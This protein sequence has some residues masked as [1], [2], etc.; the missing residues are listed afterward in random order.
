MGKCISKQKKS[1]TKLDLH[2]YKPKTSSNT[3]LDCRL[4][5]KALKEFPILSHLNF[6]SGCL[7][8]KLDS[9]R[10][11]CVGGLSNGEQVLLLNLHSKSFEHLSSPPMPLCYGNLLLVQNQMFVLGAL[12]IEASDQEKPAPPL[13]YD[14]QL[15]QWSE[16]PPMPV[17]LALCGS[18]CV[19]KDLY[20]LGGY[21]GYP[22]SPAH[23]RSMLMFDTQSASWMRSN[24]ETPILQGLP[25][26]CVVSSS[27][28][29]VIGGHDPCERITDVESRSCYVYNGNGFEKTCDIP[30]VGQL[31]FQEAPVFFNN[32]V[33]VFSDDDILF[34]YD[35]A[36]K[37]WGYIDCESSMARVDPIDMSQFSTASTYLYRFLPLDCEIEEFNITF[38]S[39]RV[40]GPSSFKYT[41]LHTGLCLLQD[42]RLFF[43][44]GLK[45]E[46]DACSSVWTLNPKLGSSSNVADLPHAQ[47]GLRMV[48]HSG[49]VYAVAGIDSFSSNSTENWCQK[50]SVAEN[51]WK[52]LPAMPC[53][54]FLPAVCVFSGRL[55]SFAGRSESDGCFMVQAMD[56]QREAWEK[57]EIEYPCSAYGLGCVGI[58]DR[59][60]CFGGKDPNECL[61]PD[62]YLFDGSEFDPVDSLPELNS[63]EFTVFNDP[64]VVSLGSVYAV[65]ISGDIFSFSSGRWDVV[66]I[67]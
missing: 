14:L 61:V 11:I 20:L 23:F 63:E 44:G 24:V 10:Y 40:T 29:L 21:V 42:N 52:R 51:T 38:G 43:A 1:S 7:F 65:S 6:Q 62:A 22:D 12:T 50:Y 32:Q 56:L 27:E 45:E 67:G 19:G 49:M 16:L 66:T 54:V 26:C 48:W 15:R 30:Q 35:M 60:L 8:R 47:F 58:S 18:F 4:S 37:E 64:P 57:L 53:S 31:R 9:M 41:F 3:L 59:V 13:C 34:I 46:G 28:V 17:K 39:K 55:F 33:L 2:Y 36:Q 5:D 25:A